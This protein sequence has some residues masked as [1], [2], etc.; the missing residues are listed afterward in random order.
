MDSE[1]L[2]V[3]LSK[4]DASV[5]ERLRQKTGLSKTDIVK[6]ALRS[7]ALEGGETAG[8]GLFELGAARFGRHGS[9]RRQSSDIKRIAKSRVRAKRTGR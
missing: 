3:R 8:G 6:R 4:D 5:I 2:T 9:A 1:F 7:L